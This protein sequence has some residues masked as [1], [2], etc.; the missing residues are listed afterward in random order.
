MNEAPDQDLIDAVI[1]AL[2]ADPDLL[3]LSGGRIFDRAPDKAAA[4][5]TPMPYVSI[6]P[7]NNVSADADCIDADDITIQID[8]WSQGP[9]DAYTGKEARRMVAQIRRI[10]SDANLS[11][12]DNA[13]V[14]LTYELSSTVRD[15]DGVSWH[16]LVQFTALVDMPST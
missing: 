8:T 3:T 16:G 4:A 5:T 15:Q 7:V 1:A 14:A 10:L 6:G 12:G 9:A 11:L 13:L 2:K